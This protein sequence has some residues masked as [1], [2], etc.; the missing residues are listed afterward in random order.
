MAKAWRVKGIRPKKSYRR[1]GRTILPVRVEEV[2]SWS[3]FI[4]DPDNI[5]ELHN[6]RISLKRLRYSMELF[7][8]NYGEEYWKCLKTVEDLQELLGDI[9][10][11]DVI[12]TVLTESLQKASADETAVG[13]NALLLHYRELRAE[14]Y[15]AFVEKWTALED[16]DFMGRFLDIVKGK[17]STESVAD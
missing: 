9:H 10:D 17:P 8:I 15:Q 13:I 5:T 11:C 3:Q 16:S 14:T 1:G 4:R 12:E 7:V 6:M 2:D